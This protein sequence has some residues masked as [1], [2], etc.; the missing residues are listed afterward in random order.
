MSMT[1]VTELLPSSRELLQNRIEGIFFRRGFTFEYTDFVL[2]SYSEPWRHY[3]NCDHILKM[4][5]L[6]LET[7]G[8]HMSDDEFY[9][10]EL[11]IMYHDVEYKIG[12]EKGWSENESA[13]VA[14]RQLRDY[15]PNAMYLD[16]V[17]DGILAT[18]QHEVPDQNWNH[19][20]GLFLDIDLLAGLGATS[21]EFKANTALIQREFEPL[22][23]AS[24]YHAGRI[25]WAEGFLDRS[26]IFITPQFEKYEAVARENLRAL[27]AGR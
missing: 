21:K 25:K 24:E 10:V 1:N 8:R 5:D 14:S 13:V 17:C 2:N 18:I 11:M 20:M 9:A 6:L 23:T 3:H 19:F 26:K 7:D 16:V 22:Y 15:V 27:I 12:R 4:L